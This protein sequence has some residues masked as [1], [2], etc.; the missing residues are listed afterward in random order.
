MIKFILSIF[1]I[2][3]NT[4]YA[5]PQNYKSSG[6]GEESASEDLGDFVLLHGNTLCFKD[7]HNKDSVNPRYTRC[8]F[9]SRGA[10][11]ES[12]ID[13]SVLDVLRRQNRRNEAIENKL[14][15]LEARI[16][17][18]SE[19]TQ[20]RVE[21]RLDEIERSILEAISNVE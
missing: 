14:T 21:V 5:W 19:S 9:V 7:S 17:E 16:N 18:L 1:V 15:A 10:G 8:Y 2:V 11:P 13:A 20:Q 6:I 12:L 3:M 4:H